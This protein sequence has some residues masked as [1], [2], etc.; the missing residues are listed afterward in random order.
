[1]VV[2]AR[3]KQRGKQIGG[4]ESVANVDGPLPLR[5]GSGGREAGEEGGG[6]RA[7]P[8]TALGGGE[9]ARETTRD[10]DWH[11]PDKQTGTGI[12]GVAR[13]HPR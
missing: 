7:A 3:C 8:S 2:R 4:E 12:A 9:L 5:A 10:D 13:N 1:M 6:A 11:G